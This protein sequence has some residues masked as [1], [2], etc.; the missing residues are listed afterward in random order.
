ME[1]RE[2]ILKSGTILTATTFLGM[3]SSS[4]NLLGA[5]ANNNDDVDYQKRPNPNSF[6]QP[7]LKAIAIGINAPSPHN[8]QSWKFK[9][10]NDTSMYLYVNENIL[11]P[12][13]DPPSRQIHM[14]AGC[15]IETLVVGASALGYS[16][17]VTLFPEG[18][19]SAKDF[20]IRPVAKIDLI[21]TSDIADELSSYINTRQTNRREFKGNVITKEEFQSLKDLTGNSYSQLV[22]INENFEPFFIEYYSR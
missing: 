9:I 17:K 8:T 20:G 3:F 19:E 14:G 2:F 10:V 4:G 13:T 12:A 7:I 22:F 18:Y 16:S 6:S 1:R 15:F 21:Q 5:I 11:L